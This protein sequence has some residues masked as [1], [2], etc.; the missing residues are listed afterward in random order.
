M[1]ELENKKCS[2]M[3]KKIA[4]EAKKLKPTVGF[5]FRVL[6]KMSAQAPERYF[7]CRIGGN[8]TPC[9]CHFGR[10]WGRHIKHPTVYSSTYPLIEKGEVIE[11]GWGRECAREE[12]RER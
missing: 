6:K 1:C 11:G 9:N 2:N 3:E 4:N 12:G 10:K 8:R 5:L 7:F